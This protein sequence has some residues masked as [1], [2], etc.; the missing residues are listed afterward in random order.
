MLIGVIAGIYGCFPTFLF[1]QFYFACST[2]TLGSA[3]TLISNP[4]WV[5][6]TSQAVRTQTLD[7]SATEG[8][9]QPKVVVKRLGVVETLRN[10]LNKDG[11]Q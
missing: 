6:Q 4:I 10:I 1:F 11:F 5:I 7:E 9:G 3:T 2:P 8:E